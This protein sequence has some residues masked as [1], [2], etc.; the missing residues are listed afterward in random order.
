MLLRESGE[1]AG[2]DVDLEVATES[3][4]SGDA[5]VPDGIELL[6]F[7]SAANNRSDSLA[8]TRIALESAVGN[9]GV[10]EAASTVAIF[11]GLVRVADGTGIQLDPSMMTSTA[12][13]RA[14]L[15]IDLFAGA[16][17]SHGAP[18]EPRHRGEGVRGLFS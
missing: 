13:T 17:N 5:G 12:E 6:A 9:E 11:N 3:N 1:R 16:A 7:A 14:A 8:E 18:T 10:L 4:R 15:G 2:L